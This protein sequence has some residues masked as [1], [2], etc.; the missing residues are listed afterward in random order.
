MTSPPKRAAKGR[1]HEQE[2]GAILREWGHLLELIL[3]KPEN[4]AYRRWLP[5]ISQWLDR[6]EKLRAA[7]KPK[8]RKR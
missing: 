6:D 1:K 7:S 3:G 4:K 2:A 8:R 5:R